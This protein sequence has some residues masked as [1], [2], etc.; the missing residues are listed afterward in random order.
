MSFEE[1]SKQDTGYL[2][3]TGEKDAR[4]LRLQHRAYG[5]ATKRLLLEAGVKRGAHV[6]EIGCG[7]GVVSCWLAQ[8]VGPE[9]RV[10]AVDISEDQLKI[11]RL[12]A[13][14]AGL[15]NLSFRRADATST[16]LPYET[17]DL[18]C[19]RFLLEHV[20]KRHEALR[21]M[22]ALLKTGGVIACE[23]SDPMSLFSYPPS[24]AYGWL[25]AHTRAVAEMAGFDFAF[26]LKL[27]QILREMGFINVS[28][29]FSQP[30]FLNGEE[31]RLPQIL[32]TELAPLLTQAELVSP[33]EIQD[34]M[35]EMEKASSDANVLV[36]LP[37]ISQVRATRR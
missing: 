14:A 10:E 18:V 31:K 11:A 28:V 24:A 15:E 25:P 16:G 9:G 29:S 12:D 3:P 26:S 6:A 19:S 35:A 17:F 37:R 8:Q 20:R 2:L 33:A 32:L 21:E 7:I 13:A 34:V 1:A 23:E 36:A 5:P 4:R 22:K 27:P 30:A